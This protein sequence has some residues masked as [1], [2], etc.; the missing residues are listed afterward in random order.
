MLFHAF[1]TFFMKSTKKVE[2]APKSKQGVFL[3]QCVSRQTEIRKYEGRR[4]QCR[5]QVQ[6]TD[7]TTPLIYQAFMQLSTT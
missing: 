5:V 4:I 6:P 7:V 3:M 2:K 1:S